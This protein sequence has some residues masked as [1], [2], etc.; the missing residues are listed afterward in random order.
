MGDL[1]WDN[2]QRDIRMVT[3]PQTY[4]PTN[5]LSRG[6]AL[7]ATAR[8][9]AN[10]SSTHTTFHP[11]T[12]SAPL[13]VHC[14]KDVEGG[15]RENPAASVAGEAVGRKEVR[16]MVFGNQELCPLADWWKGGEMAERDEGAE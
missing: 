11:S 3:Q 14:V 2:F 1:V 7:P 6:Q 5:R 16:V 10:A 13:C 8:A 15:T 12:P 4:P 9:F